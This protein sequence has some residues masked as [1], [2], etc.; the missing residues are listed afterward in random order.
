MPR[1]RKESLGAPKPPPDP[2]GEAMEKIGMDPAVDAGAVL[3]NPTV[4]APF[5]PP[6]PPVA[7]A[8]VSPVGNPTLVA[9]ETS[10]KLAAALDQSK[11][12]EK[13]ATARNGTGGEHRPVSFDSA[14]RPKAEKPLRPDMLR[15]VESIM[16]AEDID[17]VWKRLE[18]AL[19]VGERRSD[20]PVLAV[21]L[22]QAETNGR[23]AHRLYVTAQIL[24]DDWELENGP[25]FAKMR[26]EAVRSLQREKDQG[27]RSKQI[28]DADISARCSYLFEDEWREQEMRRK[29]TKYTVDS[30]KDLVEKWNSRCKSL[31]TLFG[32]SR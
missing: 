11:D 13:K 6:T 5:V 22:D 12:E 28:T 18:A 7:T 21:A 30:L 14:N 9:Q 26:D 27:E 20:G 19:Q 1:V 25:T 3:S 4:V 2:V 23:E 29:K 10:R 15:V 24:F 31:Q 8:P 32:K 16:L 17:V